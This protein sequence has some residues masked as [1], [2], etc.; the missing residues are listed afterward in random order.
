[1]AFSKVVLKTKQNEILKGTTSDFSPV[2]ASFHL[3]PLGHESSRS[4]AE[5]I[6]NDLKAVFFVKDFAGTPYRD[7]YQADFLRPK[8]GEKL[9]KVKFHDGEE[10]NGIAQSFHLDRPGFFITPNDPASNNER[11][12]VVLS[13]LQSLNVDGKAIPV[14]Q[15]RQAGCKC[16]SCQAPMDFC[17]RFC[18][19]DGSRL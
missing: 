17:W 19:F 4:S 9:L 11:I 14:E 6:V 3:I 13:D 5:I 15:L 1:M 12:Y 18:P 2:K 8:V 7:N 10:I 16:P